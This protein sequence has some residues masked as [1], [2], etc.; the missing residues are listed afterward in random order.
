M[1]STSPF[2]IRKGGGK[3]EIA[4]C[5]FVVEREHSFVRIVF[6]KEDLTPPIIMLEKYYSSLSLFVQVVKLLI[7]H[8]SEEGDIE[9]IDHNCVVDFI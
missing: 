7:S 1:I 6:D 9:D 8:Y 4:Y 5:D 2:A 3:K